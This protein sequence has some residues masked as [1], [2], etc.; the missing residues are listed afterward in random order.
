MDLNQGFP[1][2]VWT[3]PTI[4]DFKL[5]SDEREGLQEDQGLK[6]FESGLQEGQ[7]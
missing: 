6:S 7:G 2:L 3:L 5:H 4:T 1:H